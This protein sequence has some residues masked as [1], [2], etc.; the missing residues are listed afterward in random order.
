MA[1]QVNATTADDTA[2]PVEFT[3][4]VDPVPEEHIVNS[5]TDN[6]ALSVDMLN[7]MTPANRQRDELERQKLNPPIGDWVKEDRWTMD[8][9]RIL[10]DDSHADDVNK[11]GRTMLT[12]RGECKPR[13]ENGIE[14]NPMFFLRI[15]PD[16]RS[17]MNNE[18]QPDMPYKM[19]LKVEE[20]YTALYS[21][22]WSTGKD[23]FDMLCND[24]YV[25]RTYKGDNNPIADI[26]K[27]DAKRVSARR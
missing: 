20:L 16:K 10:T 27:Y 12:F 3:T 26:K 4:D 14:Y 5:N 19:W 24:Q 7:N 2:I 22:Q 13:V 18:Q 8:D 6:A 1:T 15:S 21:K 17:S 9:P 23:L 11:A 25:I